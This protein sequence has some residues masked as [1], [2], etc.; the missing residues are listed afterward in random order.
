MVEPAVWVFGRSILAEAERIDGQSA[1]D[2]QRLLE[3]LGGVVVAS[4]RPPRFDNCDLP[5][6]AGWGARCPF[7]LGLIDLRLNPRT[8]WCAGCQ[9][10]L[11]GG[12]SSVYFERADGVKACS[13]GCVAALDGQWE[14]IKPRY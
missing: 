3:D 10:A 6:L 4:E 11:R 2:V 12:R 8:M 7:R 9:A 13:D 5:E 1:E 14:K